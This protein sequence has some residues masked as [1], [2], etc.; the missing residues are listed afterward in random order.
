M[1]TTV[2]AHI[3]ISGNHEF[4]E[5]SSQEE[6]IRASNTQRRAVDFLISSWE[7][8]NILG[9]SAIDLDIVQ[10]RIPITNHQSP[11]QPPSQRTDG[12]LVQLSTRY[13]IIM[14]RRNVVMM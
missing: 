7:G 3:R 12:D 13:T 1:A 14:H 11:V 10:A 9:F 6:S 8:L 4:T 2:G 5:Q